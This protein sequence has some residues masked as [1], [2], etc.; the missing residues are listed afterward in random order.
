M[1]R[2]LVSG[3]NMKAACSR[4]YFANT[5]LGVLRIKFLREIIDGKDVIPNRI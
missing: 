1:V 4:E 5:K 3:E 2:D